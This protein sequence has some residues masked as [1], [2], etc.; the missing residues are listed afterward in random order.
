MKK[1]LPDIPHVF[2]SSVAQKGL[3]ELKDVIWRALN[4]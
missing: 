2:I 1:D 4:V 3:T